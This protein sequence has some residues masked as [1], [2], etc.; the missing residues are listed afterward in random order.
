MKIQT[1][2]RASSKIIILFIIFILLIVINPVNRELW[3]GNFMYLESEVI[4]PLGIKHGY[5]TTYEHYGKTHVLH[6]NYNRLD[7]EQ[8]A[9]YRNGQLKLKLEYRK[10]KIWNVIE[11]YNKSGKELNYGTFSNGDGMLITYWDNGKKAST[12]EMK[13]G[14]AI[15]KWDLFVGSTFLDSKIIVDGIDPNVQLIFD[16]FM[17]T[18]VL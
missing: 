14:V 11:Y 18:Y 10:G 7:G 1:Q 12:G 8:I 2:L 13:K 17:L 4:W 16:P 15:G 9:Y 5:S 3:D 6:F